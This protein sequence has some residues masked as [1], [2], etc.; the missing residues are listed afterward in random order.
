MYYY[1]IALILTFCFLTKGCIRKTYYM[2]SGKIK[3]KYYINPINGNKSGEY[4]LFSFTGDTLQV[5]LYKR[6]LLNGPFISYF[7]NGK[8]QVESN[9]LNGLLNGIQREY[10]INGKLRSEVL[11]SENRL[12][13]IITACDSTGKLVDFGNIK[14][15]SG[16]ARKYYADGS[17]EYQGSFFNG[18]RDGKWYFFSN[19]GILIDSIVYSDGNG[20]NFNI[21]DNTY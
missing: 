6:N 13:E 9:C 20:S 1:K 2:S 5:G 21:K 10:Y 17:L 4:I 19:T 16:I 18:L 8:V 3:E 14:N 11:F 12:W 7:E 15:G